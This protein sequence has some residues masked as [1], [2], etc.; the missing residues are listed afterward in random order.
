M[1]MGTQEGL[2]KLILISNKLLHNDYV[3]EKRL[4]NSF[5]KP[6]K[7][8]VASEWEEI[9]KTRTEKVT[10]KKFIKISKVCLIFDAYDVNVSKPRL[11]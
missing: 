6:P 3:T 5:G 8:F 11:L 2:T 1:L 10:Q 9:N 7:A 4:R